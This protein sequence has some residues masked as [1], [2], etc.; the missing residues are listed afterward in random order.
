MNKKFIPLTHLLVAGSM[1][2][3]SVLNSA[4]LDLQTLAMAAFYIA[5][6][7]TPNGTF[8]IQGSLDG[9]NWVN[10]GVS[11]AAAV[12]SADSRL[13]NL[14]DLAYRYVRVQYTNASSTGTLTVD[15][16]AKE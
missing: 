16:M 7:G 2:G 6:T 14:V 15:G 8:Q 12:G 5:W 11:V 10:T 1:T 3:T 13:V 9:T 4:A